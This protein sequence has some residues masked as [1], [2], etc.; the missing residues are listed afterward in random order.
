MVWIDEPIP[1]AAEA[2]DIDG[3]VLRVEFLSD[4][5]LIG[6]DEDGSDG[7]QMVWLDYPPGKHKLAARAVVK[8]GLPAVSP[9]AEI[10]ISMPR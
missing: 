10:T 8:Y 7:W 3:P 4:G 5:Q 2:G 6:Q 1:I 9:P